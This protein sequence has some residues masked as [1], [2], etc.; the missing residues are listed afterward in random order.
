MAKLK[1]TKLAKTVATRKK[2]EKPPKPFPF[3][4]LPAELRDYIYGMALTD[5]EITLV[6]KTKGQRRIVTRGRVYDD[7]D[8]SEDYWNY[9]YI[10]RRQSS[11]RRLARTQLS[12]RSESESESKPNQLVP[13]LLAVNKQIHSEAASILYKQE[14]VLEDTTA[15]L[16]FL[17]GIGETNRKLVSDL[18]LRGFGS[19]RG[20]HKANNFAS[21]TL[22]AACVNLKSLYFECKICWHSYS[23]A[24]SAS[25]LAKQIYRDAHHFL[26]AYGSANGRK[27]AAV[28]ILRF[29]DWEY[30]G[31]H[32]THKQTGDE[33]KKKFRSTLRSQLGCA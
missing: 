5:D 20:S 24:G 32:K 2:N 26:E 4:A 21:L 15:L 10:R 6:S 8:T 33:F 30:E 29:R 23:R 12:Q 9:R 18:T 22:L 13:A 1:A 14:I 28:D 31:T 19:G 11:R 3:M 16:N 7:A 27:D 25:W 17:A